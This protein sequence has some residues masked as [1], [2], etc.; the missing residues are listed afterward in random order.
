MQLP[1]T[2][3]EVLSAG[4][5]ALGGQWRTGLT[6]D[7]THLFALSDRSAKYETAMHYK[8]HTGVHVVLPHWFDDAVRLGMGNLPT[9][10]YEWPEP[11]LLNPMGEKSGL[12]KK[13][14]KDKR[15]LFKTALWT[16]GKELPASSGGLGRNI[17][18]GRRILLGA[19]LQLT[20]G[21]R[22]A[23]EAGIR[24]AGGVVVEQSVGDDEA[25]LVE[26]SD[27]LI[28]RFRSGKS[29]V[30]VRTLFLQY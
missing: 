13:A 5:A 25:L 26:S 17:W 6:R 12:G 16:P 14:D 24:R 19:S 7:V 4:I 1:P 8:Q 3:L 22:E 27:I 11:R 29:Y 2:D 15:M 28:T 23:V 18:G 20:S 10:E 21:R 30:K 9:T